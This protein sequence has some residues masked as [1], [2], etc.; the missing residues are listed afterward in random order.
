MTVSYSINNKTD[1]IR[2]SVAG[3]YS[4]GQEADE[5]KD[6][7]RQVADACRKHSQTRVLAVS[8][9]TGEM[10]QAVSF[11][12]GSN[13]ESYGWERDF[14]VAVVFADERRFES[15]RFGETILS[16]RHYEMRAFQDEE[17]AKKWLLG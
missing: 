10:P 1:H 14:R 7:W 12:I 3:T 16:N 15:N 8:R 11:S 17:A 5:A 13:P 6:I 9:I 4:R 2:L